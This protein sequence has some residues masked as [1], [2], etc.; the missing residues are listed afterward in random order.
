MVARSHDAEEAAAQAVQRVLGGTWT[1][2][3]TGSRPSQVDVLLTL[4]DGRRVALEVTSEGAGDQRGTRR[5]IEKRTARGD[6]AGA[7]LSCLWQVHVDTA[8][9]ISE[10]SEVEIERALRDFESQG[11]RSVSAL[12]AYDL[13]ADPNA[14]RLA[15]LGVETAVLWN[16]SPPSDAPKI[17][18]SQSFSV[19]GG[20]RSLPEALERVLA[21][22]DNQKKLAAADADVRH[23]Y[24]LLHDR[25]AATGLRGPWSLPACPDDP[26]GLIDAVWI[27]APWA[28]SA[29]LHRVMP[30]TDEW[31]H[32]V[33][34]TGEPARF[35]TS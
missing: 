33:M 7:S 14:R 22:T 5:A 10:L 16:P 34:A 35:K 21:R 15:R 8:T 18:I 28:S 9:I 31:E 19:I 20:H 29:Y 3:D 13:Y 24:V 1:L 17:L 27:F 26:C 6:F 4:D 2:N 25:A 23:L 32:F 11:L 30:G 12:R